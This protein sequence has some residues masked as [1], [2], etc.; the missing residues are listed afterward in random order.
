MCAGT[1]SRSG[2]SPR[3]PGEVNELGG[4]RHAL[5]G[6]GDGLLEVAANVLRLALELGPVAL[7]NADRA[8]PALTELTLHARPRPLDAALGAVAGG[9]ATA[10]ETAQVALDALLRGLGRAV[11]LRQLRDGLGDAVGGGQGGAHGDQDG[12]FGGV[13][14]LLD[15]VARGRLAGRGGALGGG[16]T[17]LGGGAPLVLG[18]GRHVLPHSSRRFRGRGGFCLSG[19]AR[20]LPVPPNTCL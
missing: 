8:G 18:G 17:A 13:L 14:D 20:T 15:R 12:T 2:A 5:L 11:R 6:L 10:L 3:R 16:A 1:L 9:R 4:A 7:R 19:S